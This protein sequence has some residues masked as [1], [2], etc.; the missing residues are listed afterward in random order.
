MT[1]HTMQNEMTKFQRYCF[2]VLLAA[3]ILLA[4]PSRSQAQKVDRSK[5]PELGP[6]PVLT[7]PPVQHFELSNGMHVILLEKHELPIV[8]IELL[9]MAGS[10]MDP[11]D[12]PGL[13]SMTAAMMEEGA[14]SRNSLQFADAIDYL[15]ANISAFAGRHTS[16]VTLHTAL[17]KL[18]SA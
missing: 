14:G 7:L 2:P 1:N 13:A 12:K 11:A 18:D 10:F 9:V 4:C 15:G 5:P 8:Q 16:S 6:P 17:S 3:L